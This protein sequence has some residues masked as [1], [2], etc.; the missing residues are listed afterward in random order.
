LLLWS[1][2][3]RRVLIRG[4]RREEDCENC[5]YSLEEE[6]EDGSGNVDDEG[7]DES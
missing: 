3:K 7:E 5:G 2:I 6:G 4:R 1:W